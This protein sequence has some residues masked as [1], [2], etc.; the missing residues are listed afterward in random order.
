MFMQIEQ[1]AEYM[2]TWKYHQEKDCKEAIV[3]KRMTLTLDT[4]CEKY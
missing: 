2:Q 4:Y 1:V 3:C